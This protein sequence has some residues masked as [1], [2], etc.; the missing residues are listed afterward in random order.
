MLFG[1]ESVS[2]G[3]TPRGP[4]QVPQAQA[5]LVYEVDPET[6]VVEPRPALGAKAHGGIRFDNHA[7]YGAPCRA[8]SRVVVSNQECR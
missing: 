4:M 8:D 2:I 3:K 6:G 7:R 5:G 1:P